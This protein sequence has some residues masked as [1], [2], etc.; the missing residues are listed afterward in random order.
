MGS[1]ALWKGYE[2]MFDAISLI[3]NAGIVAIVLLGTGTAACGA[4]LVGKLVLSLTAVSTIA[5]P[6]TR[7]RAS[8]SERKRTRPNEAY[9]A[10]YCDVLDAPVAEAPSTLADATTI[11]DALPVFAKPTKAFHFDANAA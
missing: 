10:I 5:S 6:P 3:E 1:H 2:H 11:D 9:S 4:V 7:L 8:T